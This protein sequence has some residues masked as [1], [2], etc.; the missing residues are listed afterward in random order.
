MEVCN[1]NNDGHIWDETSWP[2]YRGGLLIYIS[3]S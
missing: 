3:G 1:N 2:L